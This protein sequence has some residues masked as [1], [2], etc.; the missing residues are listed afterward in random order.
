[1]AAQSGHAVAGYMIEHSPQL[2]GE[3]ENDYLIFLQADVN[4]FDKLIG[5]LETYGIKHSKFYEPD[6]GNQ[7]TSFAVLNNCKMFKKLKPL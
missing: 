7:L 5:K 3:W 6:L 1:M 4:D 2:K